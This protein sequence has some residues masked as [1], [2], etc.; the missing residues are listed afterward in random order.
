MKLLFHCLKQEIRQHRSGLALLISLLVIHAFGLTLG[1]FRSITSPWFYDFM[2]YLTIAIQ[3]LFIGLAAY[4]GYCQSSFSKERYLATAPVPTV[5]NWGALFTLVTLLTSLF[6][7]SEYFIATCW[8]LPKDQIAPQFVPYLFVGWTTLLFG[9]LWATPAALGYGLLVISPISFLATLAYATIVEK[10]ILGLYDFH[11]TAFSIALFFGVAVIY[12][13]ATKIQRPLHPILLASYAIVIFSSL[14]I[15]SNLPPKMTEASDSIQD[16]VF[17]RKLKDNIQIYGSST[18][19]KSYARALSVDWDAINQ[20]YIVDPIA[21]TL[22]ARHAGNEFFRAT[23]KWENNNNDFGRRVREVQYLLKPSLHPQQIQY[24]SEQ[25]AGESFLKPK[26]WYKF[27]DTIPLPIDITDGDVTYSIQLSHKIAQFKKIARIP[28][29]LG[30]S[31]S[32]ENGTITLVRAEL[33]YIQQY[34]A[35]NLWFNIRSND[36]TPTNQWDQSRTYVLQSDSQDIASIGEGQVK[37]IPSM[38]P[39][40]QS[41][42]R[43]KLYIKSADDEPLKV[44]ESFIDIYEWV[45]HGISDHPPV[46]VTKSVSELFPVQ[47][48]EAHPTRTYP[49]LHSSQY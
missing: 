40:K 17:A 6:L 31:V 35:G 2:A 3:L 13:A 34:G 49:L 46:E 26:Q 32:I 15:A 22:T 28:L 33:R 4:I 38:G 44:E 16:E 42:S 12:R 25:Y 48:N 29:Q 47:S 19:R 45:Y 8:G 20:P 39:L 37:D 5:A 1:S 21:R 7:L 30:A 11:F 23:Q 43:V 27:L 24:I 36:G 41:L 10:N 9:S 18:E 14:L